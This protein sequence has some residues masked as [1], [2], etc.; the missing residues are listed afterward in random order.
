M[1]ALVA[2]LLGSP[3]VHAYAM[4]M[5]AVGA[6]MCTATNSPQ[7]AAPARHDAS[8]GVQCECCTGAAPGVA[9]VATAVVT[10]FAP[11]VP[12]LPLPAGSSLFASARFERSSLARA[13]PILA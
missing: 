6:D 11:N 9:H 2:G 5:A 13:P 7:P 3:F 4:R 12:A 1:L 8:H 10:R